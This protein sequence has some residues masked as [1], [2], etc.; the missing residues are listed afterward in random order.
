MA[1]PKSRKKYDSPRTKIPAA[2][3]REVRIESGIAC[4]V[5]KTRVS[6]E[7]H[8]IDG[9]RN[10]NDPENLANLCSNCHGM[11]GKGEITTLEVREFKRKAK[12]LDRE[13]ASLRQAVEHLTGSATISASGDFGKLKMKYHEALDDYADKIIFYQCFIY[14]IPEFFM[15]ARGESARS[16]VRD[17]L[18]VTPE[19]EKA[20]VAHMIKLGLLDVAGDLISLKDNTDAKT[21]L[22]ELIQSG[23]LDPA[24][25][26]QR[27]IE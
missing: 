19:E 6:L 7:I 14:L 8:H 16:I 18:N 17:I 13:L 10:N 5:C 22:N 2:V 20:I 9:N 11:A 27:L 15:D 23:K 3:R 25:L 4:I 1:T 12:E 24:Q 26:I 21:A